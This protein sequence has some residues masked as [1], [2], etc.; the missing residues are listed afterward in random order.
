MKNI[1]RRYLLLTSLLVIISVFSTYYITVNTIAQQSSAAPAPQTGPANNEYQLGAV[2]WMQTSGENRALAYQAF[3]LARMVLDQD[4]RKYGRKKP[5]RAIVVDADETIINNSPY[6]AWQVKNHRNYDQASW[7]DWCQREEAIAL[8]GAVEFLTYANKRGVKV[9]YITNRKDT[10]RQC[11]TNNLKKLGFP[12]VSD[13]TLL[14]RTDATGSSKESRRQD[15]A[16]KYRIVLL[17]GDNLNDFAKEFERKSVADRN[18][19]VD[20]DRDLFGSKFIALPN[21]MY[22]DWESALY[23]YNNNRTEEEKA[24]MR[25]N[26]LKAY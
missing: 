15:V 20:D 14:L 5:G 9:F 7:M 3:N 18:K 1:N 24:T 17:M 2:L 26:W 8:P 13:E 19:A 21:S 11:T 6:Q 16:K 23:E 22:G 12:E 10:E 25:L 4:I